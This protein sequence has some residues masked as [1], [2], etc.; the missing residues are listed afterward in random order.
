MFKGIIREKLRQI[1]IVLSIFRYRTFNVHSTTY[2]SGRSRISKDITV[3]KQGYIGPDA[4]IG[5]GVVIGDFFMAGAG[6]MIIGDDHVF[7][8]VG[9]PIIFSG[10]PKFKKTIIG[11]DVWIAS[12]AT[13]FR[14]IT[15]G[16]GAIIA[17]GAVVTKSVDPYTIVGG[18]PA[19]VIRKRFSDEDCLIHR[20]S[21][22][23]F[24]K[25]KFCPPL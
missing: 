25:G 20:K 8:T 1:K 3:G 2:L 23:T 13:V 19:K 22:D 9:I 21:L 11:D 10:R 7:D 16:D 12:R 18:V 5:P 14:G 15:I 4:R 6:L 24:G 17:A